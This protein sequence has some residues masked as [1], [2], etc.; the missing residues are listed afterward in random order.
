MKEAYLQVASLSVF[1][2]AR[3]YCSR[4]QNNNGM[5]STSTVHECV[6][7]RKK[8][9]EVMHF[10]VLWACFLHY[11][12]HD[13]HVSAGDGVSLGSRHA[14]EAYHAHTIHTLVLRWKTI[15]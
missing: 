6:F 9:E 7:F 8:K 12:Q 1:A 10:L 11:L 4:R 13:S 14:W 3:L 2:G 5:K 15:D